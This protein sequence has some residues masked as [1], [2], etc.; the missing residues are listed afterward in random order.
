MLVN[1]PMRAL[2]EGPRSCGLAAACLDGQCGP[3]ATDGQC[4]DGER[5]VLDH[6]VLAPNILCRSHRDCSGA[7]ALCVLSGYP[8]DPRDNADMRAD[9]LVSK[10]GK[11]LPDNLQRSVGIPAPTPEVNAGERMDSV[12]RRPGTRRRP[13]LRVRHHISAAALSI[14]LVC[15]GCADHTDGADR[16][17]PICNGEPSVRLAF[18]RGGA[19][20]TLPGS[21]VMSENGS[22][23]LLVEGSCR[24]WFLE[25]P[26]SDVRTVQLSDVAAQALAADM[27]LVDWEALRGEYVRNLCDGPGSLLRFGAT[28]IVITSACGVPDRAAAVT[29]L[30]DAARRSLS[31]AYAT[32]EPVGGSVRFVLVAEPP[33]VIWP[34]LV[35]AAA[36]PWPLAVAPETL[37]LSSDAAQRY[38]P[39]SSRALAP[40]DAER[41][42]ELRRRF[43]AAGGGPLS[44]GFIPVLGTAGARYQLF[45][46]DAIPLEDT[47]GLL[48]VDDPP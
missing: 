4:G 14:L 2:C 12:R 8:S 31:A 16:S 17:A 10:D 18:R 43:F 42:R 41:V 38:Q 37:A 33:D 47:T 23:F 13:A 24:A 20:Q 36:A 29:W 32:A 22:Q 7:G 45:V 44:G 28:R 39:G 35:A 19:G 30:E 27:H 5:C 15:G 3:C 1:M 6:C 46:R 9:G 34:P 21:Q 11:G 40:P 48:H 25:D 26:A